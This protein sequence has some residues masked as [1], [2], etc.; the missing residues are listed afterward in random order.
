MDKALGEVVK[1]SSV[2][3]A[4]G[5]IRRTLESASRREPGISVVEIPAG[6]MSRRVIDAI[7]S[8]DLFLDNDWTADFRRTRALLLA[9]MRALPL[10]PAVELPELAEAERNEIV[11]AFLA[12]PGTAA[13]EAVEAIARICLDYTYDYLGDGPYRWSPIVVEQFMLDHVPRKVSLDLGGLREL[14]SVLRSWVRF[15]LTRR[16]IEERWIVETEAAVDEHARAFR[17][18][19]TDPA[20]FGPAKVIEAAMRADHVDLGDQNAI[21]AWIR[22]FNARSQHERDALLGRIPDLEP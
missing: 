20:T 4:K 15:A 2:G 3:P 8:G 10:G 22:G 9:R 7:E 17:R 6:T 14:P 19:A 16:G 12:S 5:D 18:E 13:G 21:E 1:D 11:E